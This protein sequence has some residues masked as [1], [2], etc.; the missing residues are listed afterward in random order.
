MVDLFM[1]G[2]S[3]ITT[4]HGGLEPERVETQRRMNWFLVIRGSVPEGRVV[5]A[6][7]VAQGHIVTWSVP[8]CRVE[9]VL[10]SQRDAMKI[11]RQFSAGIRVGDNHSPVGTAEALGV[12]VVPTGLR[13][14]RACPCPGTEAPGYYRA[15]PTGLRK[16]RACPCPG[17]EVPGYYQAAPAGARTAFAPC[18]A[19]LSRA[20][21]SRTLRPNNRCR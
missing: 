2:E 4:I 7:Q 1:P 12:S 20:F 11:A 5:L 16:I 8:Q 17:T 14:I 3:E 6:S 13:K 19:K 15:V 9:L 21:S 18:H 10:A